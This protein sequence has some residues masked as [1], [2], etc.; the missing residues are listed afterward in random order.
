MCDVAPWF[1]LVIVP[2]QLHRVRT[3]VPDTQ[4]GW[5]RRRSL[6]SNDS[7]AV[8]WRWIS[9][10][11]LVVQIP[12]HLLTGLVLLWLHC[13]GDKNPLTLEH[14]MYKEHIFLCGWKQICPQWLQSVSVSVEVIFQSELRGD[15]SPHR[16]DRCEDE[17]VS[18]DLIVG[19]WKV[20]ITSLRQKS[21]SETSEYFYILAFYP[22]CFHLFCLCSYTYSI[23]FIPIKTHL[24][25]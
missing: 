8:V 20:Q 2:D 21:Q 5:K 18:R 11:M 14:N 15:R 3:D 24:K 17:A 1:L 13:T 16:C 22:F 4:W 7:A 6:C 9:C 23:S 10:M 12:T 25:N 19:R